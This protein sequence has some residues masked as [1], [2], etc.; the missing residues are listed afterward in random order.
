MGFDLFDL[1]IVKQWK[2]I[3]LRPV[4][5][6]SKLKIPVKDARKESTLFYL[7]VVTVSLALVFI[8]EAITAAIRPTLIS[9]LNVFGVGA[10]VYALLL[11]IMLPI[12]VL[13]SWG[14]LYVGTWIVHMFARLFGAKKGYD[15]TFAVNA[16]S[17]APSIFEVIPFVNWL[18]MIY[19]TVLLIVGLKYQQQMST[20][21][22]VSAVLVPLIIILGI[23]VAVILVFVPWSS[24]IV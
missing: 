8:V 3:M 2:E 23:A 18:S 13:F 16:Y 6:F 11:L 7:K 15:V 22:A 21:G 14:W 20:L 5:F 1:G 10:G 19:S 9:E 4:A 12:A 24:L 17:T